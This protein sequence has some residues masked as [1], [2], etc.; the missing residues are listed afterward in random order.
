MCTFSTKKVRHW[1]MQFEPLSRSILFLYQNHHP[2]FETYESISMTTDIE[3]NDPLQNFG[4]RQPRTSYYFI[5]IRIRRTMEKLVSLKKSGTP[6]YPGI[7]ECVGWIPA[8]SGHDEKLLKIKSGKQSQ[9]WDYTISDWG[10]IVKPI[11]AWLIRLNRKV[12]VLLEMSLQE[13]TY[14]RD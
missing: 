3:L 2:R 9:N 8:K 10:H 12:S 11:L 6:L 14:R 13:S 7:S 5:R 4:D 1:C